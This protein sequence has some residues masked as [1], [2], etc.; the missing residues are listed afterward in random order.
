MTIVGS[1]EE[2]TILLKAVVI[3]QDRIVKLNQIRKTSRFAVPGQ[4]V[5]LGKKSPVLDR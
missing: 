3:K 2:V 1:L 5:K 4:A